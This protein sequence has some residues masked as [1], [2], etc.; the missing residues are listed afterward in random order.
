LRQRLSLLQPDAVQVV[1]FDLVG[2][3]EAWKPVTDFLGDDARG[4]GV[5]DDM[6]SHQL[7]LLPWL[8]RRS[9]SRVR[10]RGFGG[11]AERAGTIAYELEFEDGLTAMCNVG[12]AGRREE[13]LRVE[14]RN[15]QLVVYADRLFELDRRSAASTR[16][17][18]R[19]RCVGDRVLHR[20]PIE[21]GV[22]P[23]AGQLRA[24]ATA[25]RGTDGLAGVADGRSGVSTVRV[26][27]ACRASMRSGG[28][29][30]SVEPPSTPGC[31]GA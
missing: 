22:T 14:L 25:A 8:M 9:V 4:G 5:L 28:S 6:A 21:D 26:V 2:N 18:C 7:D 15:R 10:A 19:L 24:F 31:G 3:A 13:T 30:I 29:W 16:A 11:T 17:Y 12:H 1:R 27:G 20:H 23:F